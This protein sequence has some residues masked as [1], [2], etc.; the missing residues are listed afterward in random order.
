LEATL[1]AKLRFTHVTLLPG[2]DYPIRPPH[3]IDAFF[4]AHRGTSFMEF[5]TKNRRDFRMHR[6]RFRNYWV[7]FAGRHWK[8]PLRKVGIRRSIP[9][10]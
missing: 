3:E 7:Y 4:D 9:G 2:Q 8:V 10:G 6:Y 5:G 1:R